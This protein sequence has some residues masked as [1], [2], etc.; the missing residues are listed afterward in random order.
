MSAASGTL[1]AR[2]MRRAHDALFDRVHSSTLIYNTCW[3]DPRLDRQ[4]LALQPDS[5]IVMITSAG[6]NALDYLL[7]DPAEIHAVDVNPRQNALLHLKIALIEH[8]D[9]AE[10]F[11]LFGEGARPDFRSLLGQLAHRLHPYATKFW[12]AKHYY[13]ESTR[14]NPSFYYRGAAGWVAWVLLQ[15][16]ARAN[17]SVR[18]LTERLVEAQSLEEQSALYARLQAA[19]WNAFNSWLLNQPLTMAMLGVPRPQIQI[20][21][22]KF[23]GGLNGYIRTKLEYVLTKLPMRDNYFWR[24]YATGRYTAECCPNYLL[25]ENFRSLGERTDRVSTHSTTIANFLR[26]NPGEYTHYVL[27]DHQNWLASHD[28]E[29]L[30]EEWDLVLKNSRPGT[31]ILMRSASPE[32]DFIPAPVRQRLRFFTELTDCLHLQDRVGTYGST[33][34]AEVR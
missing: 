27:L 8:G 28:V 33:L 2:A 10:L 18:D 22:E 17:P 12:E 15:G 31:R 16:L 21:E 13:F 24:V 30:R 20:I 19:I 26:Q 11:R 34:L 1:K 32:I 3:E 6:C 23:P 5:R 7:D 9:H 14:M 4:L 25:A 29:G